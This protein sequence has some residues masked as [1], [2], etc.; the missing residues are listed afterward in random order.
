MRLAPALILALFATPALAQ[1]YEFEGRVE[2][3]QRAELA[4]RLDGRISE[5]HFR[6]GERVSENQPL[7]RLEQ[8]SYAHALAIAEANLVEAMA[9]RQRAQDDAARADTLSDRGVGSLARQQDAAATLAAAEAAERA[10]QA[11]LDQARLDLDHTTIVAPIDGVI[12]RPRAA[13]GGFV[14]AKAGPA[15]A[16]VIQIDPVLVAYQVPY[17]DRLTAL[18][19]AEAATVEALHD[20]MTLRL[21]LPNGQTYPLTSRPEFASAD[22]SPETGMLSVWASFD[23]PD[24]ILRPGMAVGILSTIVEPPDGGAPAD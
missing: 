19:A 21:V 24:L 10:A 4:S 14:E 16:T 20:R 3:I 15:L 7:I 18:A 2:A 6:G 13:L 5:I 11:A 17:A 12:S 22:V 8:E 9:R 1:T 23:N